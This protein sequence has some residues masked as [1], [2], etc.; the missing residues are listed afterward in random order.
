MTPDPTP[1]TDP[2]PN[3]TP[4]PRPPREP[5]AGRTC[6]VEPLDIAR[7]AEDLH[8][9]NTSTENWAY[10]PYGP[11]DTLEGYKDHLASAFGDDPMCHAVVV[12][13]RAVGVATYLRI[14][15]EA[16][17]IEVGH[18]NYSPLLQRTIAATEAMHLMM[19]RA[20]DLGYRRYE[21]KCNAANAASRAAALRL[22]FA[23]EGIHRQA[24]VVKGHNRDTAWFSILDKEWPV[25]RSAQER[26]LSPE[27]FD[28]DGNQR[29]SLTALT[30]EA[31][32]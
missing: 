4:P 32:S 8:A 31:R 30:R 18:I 14:N 7:H 5:M 25:I 15:P 29:E 12:G 1:N 21:W 2:V 16:G 10:L 20:F 26:W 28:A 3:W 24:L 19:K 11:Y 27:N 22:G 13:G 23:Y 17:S 6:T 9:A